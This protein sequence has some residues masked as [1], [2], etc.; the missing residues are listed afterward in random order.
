MSAVDGNTPSAVA[1][2]PTKAKALKLFYTQIHERNVNL[3]KLL[4][5]TVLPV[6]YSEDFY[7]KVLVSSSDWTKMGTSARRLKSRVKVV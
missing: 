1:V 6:K 2:K 4:V 7:K 5:E 3:V